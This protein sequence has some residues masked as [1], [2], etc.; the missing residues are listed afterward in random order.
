MV[1]KTVAQYQFLE[2]LGAGGMGDIYK[3]QDTRL[4]RFVAIKVLTSASAGDPERRR[5][6]LQ[7][8]QAASA[9]NHPNIIVIH[10]IISEDNSDNMVMEYVQGKT[11]ADLIP[12]GGLRVPLV[13]KLGLQMT[14]ALQVAH[15]AGIIHRDLKPGN[16]MVTDTGL[17]KIL[18]FGLAK[19]TDRGPLSQAGAPGDATQTIAQQPLTIEGSIIGTVSYMSPEQAQGHKVDTR[20]DIFSLGVVLYEMV[21]GSRAFAGE[22][23]LS[24]LSAILRDEARPIPEIVPDVPPQLEELISRCLRKNVD[25][26]FQTMKDVQNA[27]AAL[28]HDSDSGFLYRAPVGAASAAAAPPPPSAE[29]LQKPAAPEKA[30]ASGASGTKAPPKM[31]M[32]AAAAVLGV[33]IIGGGIWMATRGGEPEAPPAEPVAEVA[34][35]GDGLTLTNDSIIQMVAANVPAEVVLSQI[36]TSPTD[37]DLSPQ[38]VIRLSQNGVP[39]ILIEAMR[40]PSSIPELPPA[41]PEGSPPPDKGKLVAKGGPKELPPP[42]K[43]GPKGAKGA[44]PPSR[45]DKQ[46][47]EE[48]NRR[49]EQILKPPEAPPAAAEAPQPPPAPTR[50]ETAAPVVAPP[51]TRQVTLADGKPFEIVLAADIPSNAAAGSQLRF[52]VKNAVRSDDGVIVIAKGAPVTGQIAQAGK[53][54]LF[55]SSK[56]TLRLLTVQ[57]VDGKTY[58]VRALSARN[59]DDEPERSVETSTKP[60]SDD[61]AASAGAEYIAYVDGEMRVSVRQ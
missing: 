8:A 25:D 40:N 24:T 54:R 52:T 22:S 41:P 14:D 9:L 3:A 27:L 17:V 33:L 48:F 13:L 39:G 1:G 5:R 16:V 45:N 30:A 26:R 58:K 46:D 32:I 20:S 53:R 4:N 10:D 36:R 47:K 19:L 38:G 60:K 49:L 57:A 34:P 11:L 59:G 55:G 2:K 23:A 44:P 31:A 18:D 21:T 7:E 43:S 56:A 12:K 37:F 28:K 15:S 29:K 61:M 6:F 35:P 42:P 50:A 51:P